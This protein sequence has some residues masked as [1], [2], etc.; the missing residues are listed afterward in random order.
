VARKTC[1][2]ACIGCGK[3]AKACPFEAITVANNV[4]YIDFTKCKACRK[5]VT[6]CPTGAIK[7]VNFPTPAKKQEVAS[8]QPT[9]ASEAPKPV[10][11]PAN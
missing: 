4:A 7:D 8:P 3:C 9:A 1:G 5:C 6:E 10:A 2:N 11:T